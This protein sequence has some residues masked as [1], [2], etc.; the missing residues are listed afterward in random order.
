MP[1]SISS[2][3]QQADKHSIQTTPDFGEAGQ[4]VFIVNWL[5]ATNATIPPWWSPARDMRLRSFWKEVDYLSGAVY[6]MVSKMTAI[7]NRVVPRDIS[8]KKYAEQANFLTDVL[9][10]TPGKGEGWVGEYGKGVEDL[11]TTDNGMFFEVIGMGDPAGPILGQPISFAHLDSYRCSRTGDPI[12]P[13]IYTDVTGKR[14]KLHYT[15]VMYASQMP[16]PI[17][18]MFGVGFSAVSRCL[19]IAQSLLD[20]LVFKQEKMGSRPHREIIIT[21]GGLDPADLAYAFARSEAEMNNQGL[22]RY[23]KMVIGGNSTLPEADAKQLELSSLPDGFDEEKSI[24]YGMATIAL[25]FGVDA[26]ELFP[27]MSSGATRADALLQHLKQ[28]GKGPGQILQLTEQLFN[29]KFVPPHLKFEFDFQDDAEDRQKAEIRGFRSNARV[30]DMSTG[31]VTERVMRER[32]LEDG[33][34]TRPQFELM[35][36]ESG[37]MPN[38]TSVLTLFYQKNSEYSRLLDIGIEDPAN[39]EKN[40]PAKVLK[41][42]SDK[43]GDIY[44]HLGNAISA[45]SLWTGLAANSALDHLE[46]I[47]QEAEAN[48]QLEE[49]QALQPG[50]AGGNG[51]KPGKK[52]IDPRIRTSGGVNPT[53]RNL[54]GG[55]NRQDGK[56]P[57]E[58]KP[59]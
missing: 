6:T 45:Q 35:E 33:D 56:I 27:A 13:V 51:N 1:D 10:I 14:Y 23:S 15:R 28:R 50:Q 31:T 21:Q 7:P 4:G 40:D 25:A 9:H 39:V 57:P 52:Y 58:D 18:E 17:K 54:N 32:M 37:R 34:V 29:Y 49:M 47:Y 3:I 43:R 8:V 22:S 19:N 55:D 46:M 24:V 42:I 26:R 38:G 2:I 59:E 36:L 48:A 53:S 41:A 12:Y 5:A 20:I 11:L 16:S 30:Q 44:T